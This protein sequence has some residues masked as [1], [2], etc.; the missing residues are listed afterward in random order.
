MFKLDRLT[1]FFGNN[2]MIVNI[3]HFRNNIYAKI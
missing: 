1:L 3:G 2:E